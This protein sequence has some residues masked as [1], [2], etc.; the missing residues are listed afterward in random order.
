MRNITT[1]FSACTFPDPIKQCCTVTRENKQSYECPKVRRTRKDQPM[2]A[3]VSSACCSFPLQ[4]GT[5]NSPINCWI[6]STVCTPLLPEFLKAKTSIWILLVQWMGSVGYR[7]GF[8]ATTF[9][10]PG[11]NHLSS[12]SLVLY[13]CH[14]TS[15]DDCC[16]DYI[17]IFLKV[18]T[19]P[20]PM[21]M[22]MI[23]NLKGLHPVQLA[24][25]GHNCLSRKVLV[26]GMCP[27]C[28]VEV[29]GGWGGSGSRP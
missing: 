22:R 7:Y 26:I 15:H 24:E 18:S 12:L 10:H 9:Q 20:W 4:N 13:L 1:Q 23:M 21:M 14:D 27:S 2:S 3:L 6:V 17:W 28:R 5:D 8:L 11:A 25:E 19:A 29:V 16:E